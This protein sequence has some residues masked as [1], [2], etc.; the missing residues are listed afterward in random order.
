MNKLFSKIAA[1][2][3]GLAMAIG[4]GV[5]VG[6]NKARVVKAAEGDEL[7]SFSSASV[8]GGTATAYTDYSDDDWTLNIGGNKISAGWNKT[9]ANARQ[10]GEKFA[11]DS[12]VTSTTYGWV[13]YTKSTVA[14]AGKLVFSYTGGSGNGDG[15]LWLASSNDGETYSKVTLSSGTQG[16]S[17]GT[18][19]TNYTFEFNTIDSAYYAIIVTGGTSGSA[20]RFDNVTATLYEGASVDPSLGT[21]YIGRIQDGQDVEYASSY[22]LPYSST[23]EIYRFG[24]FA[25]DE[26]QYRSAVSAISWT[27]SD[28]SIVEVSYVADGIARLTTKKAGTVTL[29][30]SHSASTKLYNDA[31]VTLV[32][33]KGWVEEIS[34]SG[35]MSKTEYTTAESWSADG[36]VVT[37]TYHWTGDE[38]VTSG[39]TWTFS[40]AAPAEGVTSVVATA[41][42]EGESASSSAQAV[43]VTKPVAEP[44]T[45]DN[46]YTVAQARAAIDAGSGTSN[47]YATGIVSKI[48][49]EYSSTFFNVTFN[50]STDGSTSAVQLQAFR[51]KSSYSST[52]KVGDIVVVYGSLTKYNSTYEFGQNCA[53]V[54]LEEP[55]TPKYEVISSIDNGTLNVSE[56]YEGSTL[57]VSVVGNIGYKYPSSLTF[58]RMAGV[59]VQYTYVDGVV[60]VQN[61]QG[62]ITIEG[63]CVA[64]SKIE[65]LYYMPDSTSV[66]F[67]GVYVGFQTGNGPIVMDGEFGILLYKSSQ[68]VSTYEEGVTVLH[69]TGNMATFNGL[70][71]VKDNLTI[72]VASG[73][74]EAPATPVTYSAAGGET[75]EYASRLTHVTGIPTITKGTLVD[76]DD[77]KNDVTLS[78]NL[79]NDKSVQVFY[80]VAAQKADADAFAALKEAVTGETSITIKGFTGWYNGFQV[81]MNGYVPAKEDYTAEDFAQDL[82]NQTDEVCVNYVDGES[83]Y[84][85]FKAALTTIWN[86]LASD[87][88]Y[89]SLS[90]DEKAVLA[91]AERNEEGTIVEQAMARYD[92]LT[93]KYQLSNFING[94][95]P[96]AAKGYIEFASNDANSM[97]IIIAIAATSAI[98]LGALL[99][100]KKK[101]QK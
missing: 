35:S 75:F 1:L 91:E 58:V 34:V 90:E 17:C 62:N 101:K 64:C 55:S 67:Y 32:V 27:S 86:D 13:A 41:T 73:E 10:V 89:Q 72:E 2:S 7:L 83:G 44:G 36:L 21:L 77:N 66:D 97:I 31:S 92:F 51:E 87:D 4:V 60:T 8:V 43:T 50:I 33:D 29:T 22:T 52:V 61:V 81:Q 63:S 82:M 23:E 42:F 49:T 24:A 70:R 37:A 16:S 28:S 12:T 53:I 80:K 39:I 45:E 56:V 30:A 74:Y 98:A 95:T 18:A 19:S 15:K 54:S 100:L 93:G 96:V 85:E 9:A 88:K 6:S 25:G 40:P 57:E 59:D 14:K 68:D 65:S 79:G 47:V 76:D 3:V 71:Q 38:V 78:F 20:F 84:A 48:V 99:I 94:R 46:P 11:I 69:V 5:A 26:V